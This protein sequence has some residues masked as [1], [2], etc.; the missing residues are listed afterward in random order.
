MSDKITEIAALFSSA[1][2]AH[3]QAYIETDGE[4]PEW[5]IWYAN[6]LQAPLSLLLDQALTISM[7]VYWVIKLDM[8]YRASGSD[9]AWP[10]WY[11]KRVA[12]AH[13]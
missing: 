13:R 11:A 2:K 1:G 7:I 10:T 9:E 3:H 6:F 5:P 4:D 8:D 12:E